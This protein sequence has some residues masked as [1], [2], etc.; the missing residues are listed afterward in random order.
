MVRGVGFEPTQAYAIGSS[1]RRTHITCD[2][3]PSNDR[4]S[5]AISQGY[6]KSNT[7]YHD[8]ERVTSNGQNPFQSI[9]RDL[10][11]LI[12]EYKEYVMKKYNPNTWKDYVRYI[13]EYVDFLINPARNVDLLLSL[14]P[15]HR[16]KVLCTLSIFSQFLDLKLGTE[17]FH[18]YFKKLRRKLKIKWNEKQPADIFEK[19]TSLDEA[20]KAIEIAAEIYPEYAIYL[21]TLLESG[22]RPIELLTVRK[23]A[24]R[25]QLRI[26]K[27]MIIRKTKRAF[28][29][30][31]GP[32]LTEILRDMISRR[33]WTRLFELNKD[34]VNKA[35]KKIREEIPWFRPYHLRK[36]N[37][38]ILLKKGVDSQIVD[39]LQGR[40]E[41]TV[42]MQH[43][44]KTTIEELV[45]IHNSAIKE[46]D[47]KI[48]S[49]LR[50]RIP[51]SL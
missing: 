2:I 5:Q 49:I 51:R 1:A 29:G 28:I 33:N 4:I 25:P 26:I 16:N 14:S 34:R 10:D 12:R 37:A 43:Y 6:S 40:A 39:L 32:K 38:S 13:D 31:L 17:T 9:V 7:A 24:F 46:I 23:E 45:K 41:A 8:T 27:V 30:I 20:L 50:P 3:T 48:Y 42:L 36:L 21:A 18:D 15:K 35:S 19:I 47:D 22:L 44:F 11:Y